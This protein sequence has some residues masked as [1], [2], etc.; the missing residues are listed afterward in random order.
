MKD[1]INFIISAIAILLSLIT[2]FIVMILGVIV[3]D[4]DP[5][6]TVLLMVGLSVPTTIVTIV[7]VWSVIDKLMGPDGV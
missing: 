6:S 7:L 2:P 1:I 4:L 5:L 3:F